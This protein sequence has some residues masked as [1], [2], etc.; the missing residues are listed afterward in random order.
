M[1]TSEG[2]SVADYGQI[3]SKIAG[4]LMRGVRGDLDTEANTGDDY[5]QDLF[6]VAWSAFRKWRLSPSRCVLGLKHEH[7]YICK[8]LWN[9]ADE[10]AKARLRRSRKITMLPLIEDCD[11]LDYEFEYRAMVR[12]TLEL[13][14]RR[15]HPRDW[16]VLSDIALDKEHYLSTTTCATKRRR[17][18]YKKKL[19]ESSVNMSFLE[20]QPVIRVD[21]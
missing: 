21:A 3:A 18:R 9:R 13:L 19:R 15:L 4:C 2:F 10:I 1:C 6:L 16:C 7:R 12:Q 8:A 14:K 5:K 11:L 20:R 17:Q